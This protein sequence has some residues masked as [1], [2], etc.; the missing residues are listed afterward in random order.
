MKSFINWCLDNRLLVLIFSGALFVLGLF[1]LAK[2]HL[3]AIPDLSD[4]Q[5]IV[6]V[7]YMGQPP[8][9]VEDQVTYPL[10]TR[11]LSV[12]KAKNV[13]GY[14]FFGF[15]LVYILF[16]DGTDLYWARSRVL[17]YLSSMQSK[18]PRGVDV[19]L[20][21][22]ATAL[23]WIYEYALRDNTGKHNL[24]DLRDLQEFSLR[25]ELIAVDGVSDVETMGG[26]QRQFQIE[27]NP[28]RLYNYNLSFK[29]IAMAVERGNME[30]GARLFE[31]GETEYMVLVKGYL[32]SIED[33]KK[34]PVRATSEGGVLRIEDI[35]YVKEG[36]EL[37]RGL[38]DLNGE[39][40]VVGGVVMMRQGEDVVSTITGV[41]KRIDE[42]RKTL[43]EGVEIITTYDRSK[44]INTAITNL[45]WK[46]F[47]ELL[48][49]SIVTFIFLLH[50]RS[51]LVALVV[52]PLGVLGAFLVM[53]VLGVPAN[54][55]SMGGIAI[56]IGVMVDA[57]VVMVENTHKHLEKI[58]REKI[59]LSSKD[60]FEASREAVLEVAPGLFWSMVIIVISFL[61]VF[62][63][64]EQSGRLFIPLALT[65]TLAMSV[66]AFLAIT[67]LP[68][69]VALFV[70]GK[71]KNEEDHPISKV[72]I[73][74]YDPVL[75]WCLDHKTKVFG[76]FGVLLVISIIPVT[77]IQVPFSKTGKKLIKPIGSEFMPPLEEGDLLYMPTTIPGISISKAREILIETDKM[78]KKI[79]EVDLV[80]GKAG[81]SESATDPAPLSMLETNI[82]IKDKQF[83]RK[84]MTMEKIV[85][86]LDD[87]VKLPGVVNA[88]TMPIKTRIDMLSTGIRTPIGV[89][90]LGDDLEILQ[91]ISQSLE[92]SLKKINGVASVFGERSAG[93]NYIVFDID[94]DKAA[95]Y[96][97]NI[98]DI[99]DVISG[100]LGGKEVTEII[101]GRFRWSA[102]IRYARSSRESLEKLSDIY[103]PLP[104][105]RGQIPVSQVAS[106]KITKGPGVIKT[107]NARKTAWIYVDTR[108]SDIGSLVVNIRAEIDKKIASGELHWPAGYSYIISGQYEQM[109]LASDRMM[110]LIP[111]V[112][113]IV[114]IILFIHF[115]SVSNSLFVMGGSLL[116][117]PLG[118]LWFMFIAGYNNSVASSVGFIALIGLA[119]ET[120]VIMLIYLES[121]IGSISGGR[122]KL[123]GL[124]EIRS[125]VVEGAVMRV[126]PKMMTVS[127]TIIGLVPLF[128]G[129]DPGNVAMRRIAA[130]M[131]GGLITSTVVTLIIIPMMYEWWH[132][133]KL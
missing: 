49:V 31:Q 51:A 19:E 129:S 68:V 5:V 116:F 55:M 87:T 36:P 11:M 118:G 23:G 2:I 105:G 66:S 75:R 104:G 28:D 73:R 96:G 59:D 39:G 109:K 58:R 47:E 50:L 94:R 112:I 22:D 27:V 91:H 125:A 99:Q 79:P 70:R 95:R 25:Y 48:V 126:R 37:R 45:Y 15:S 89:K 65:K 17:E 33:V 128:W 16:E 13:R 111:L 100:A 30:M 57:S 9:V 24:A 29:E 131:V 3:D 34:I 71:I 117:A 21:P 120:G 123:P 64:P 133:R 77:G 97:L 114:F 43:P 62:A 110:F 101:K 40:E 52:L 102:N 72:L 86:E 92:G 14:S 46:L 108:Q 83:W 38:A 1:S 132:S 113:V 130:P 88:W 124:K 61:P 122:K 6:Q 26:Y 90:I 42:L 78:I 18:L 12:P 106:I 54:I 56:A 103:I 67:L 115:K 121:A 7:K 53:Y 35:G 63:L 8:E 82:L 81:R 44:I 32:T 20:G 98:A 10:T 4:T 60:Y 74:I 85:Q 107:E 119:A 76:A 41:K 84:G 127:T 69:L 93:A 80:F